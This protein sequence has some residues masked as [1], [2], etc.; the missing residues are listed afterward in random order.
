[1]SHLTANEIP[2]CCNERKSA[3][4]ERLPSWYRATPSN[5]RRYSPRCGTVHHLPGSK[6]T[7]STDGQFVLRSVDHVARPGE[8]AGVFGTLLV[9]DVSTGKVR[10]LYDYVGHVAWSGSDFIIVT[11]YV[12]KK[13]SRA[14]VFPV[15]PDR[16]GLVIDKTQLIP[17]LP[18]QQHL[19]LEQN[20]TFSWKLRVW[21]VER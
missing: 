18:E 16:D 5:A 1:M 20:V 11:D 8:F 7:P 17:L 4:R 14:I 13:T 3:H 6:R 19:Q 2:T 21:R 9:E 10:K 12:N 15:A